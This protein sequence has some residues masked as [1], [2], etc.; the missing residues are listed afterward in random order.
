[1]TVLDCAPQ[2]LKAA[3]I[4]APAGVELSSFAQY[5]SQFLQLADEHKTI[6]AFELQ[7]LLERCLPN[8]YIKSC[9]TIETC[10]QIVLSMEVLITLFS[11]QLNRTQSISSFQRTKLRN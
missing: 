10:R 8:D 1:M 5:E 2:M 4:K 6:N 9:A 3:L 11:L 7:E